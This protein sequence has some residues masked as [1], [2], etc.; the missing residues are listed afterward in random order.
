VTRR[1]TLL[2]AGLVGKAIAADLCSDFDVTAV[3]ADAAAL[4][5][6]RARYPIKTLAA[7]LTDAGAVRR[8]VRDA[9]LVIG[10]VPG[11]LGFRTLE[12]VI[13][14]GK[15]VVDISFFAED[16]L[17][18]D[19]LAKR[20]GV[21]AV[22]DCGVAPGMGNMILGYW[23]ER[24]RVASFACMVGGLPFVRTKP[25]EY[26]APFSPADVLEE[27]TRPA[28]HVENG[29]VVVKPALSDPE[30]VEFEKVGTL[31]AFNTDGLRTLLK[32][33]CVPNMKEK[34]LRYPG[35]IG[36]IRTLRDA[37]FFQKTPLDVSGQRVAPF[38][39]TARLL[40]DSWKLREGEEE[41]TVGRITIAG[42]E[43]GRARRITYNLFD[44]Y[45]R[46]TGITS[47]ARTTAY[48]CT[49]VARLVLENRFVRNGVSPP[50]YVGRQEGCLAAV[51]EYLRQRNVVYEVSEE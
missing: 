12:T 7:D 8:V 5:R 21:T 2:G 29:C 19:E 47:M 38:D 49:A 31:E 9:D 15:N 17:L 28:R 25:F 36:L 41:F 50:E 26:K 27:Y 32:T 40:F 33:V 22:V 34:T 13:D 35:H 39:V 42:E 46:A 11:F 20:R 3:D 45:D 10:A 18:L 48:A 37:G 24:L 1:I 14:A 43:N 51:L 30:L 23:V 44:V 4:E 16:A 6:L